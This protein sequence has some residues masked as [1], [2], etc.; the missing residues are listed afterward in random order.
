MAPEP[1]LPMLPITLPSGRFAGRE[2]FAQM[3][4]DAF[5]C[6]AQQGWREIV[7]SD[8]TF[9]DWPLKERAVVESLRA[10]STSGR[11]F[12]MLAGSYDLLLRQQPRFVTWRK[13]WGH[14]VEAR[15]CRNIDAADFPSLFWSPAWAMRRLDLLRSAGVCSDLP[16]R[17]VHIRETL[18]ELLLGSSPGFPASTLGL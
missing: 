11:R 16:E 5:A 6:A 13:T 18:D 1:T 15:L 9:E 3:L 12:V 4:R 7:I 14:I 17:R 8:A 2:A 10:W